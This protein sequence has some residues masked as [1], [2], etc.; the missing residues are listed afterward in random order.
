M[1]WFII[2]KC[3]IHVARVHGGNARNTSS[4]SNSGARSS[5]VSMIG[6]EESVVREYIRT[7]EEGDKRPDQLEMRSRRPRKGDSTTAVA[8][9]AALSQAALSGSHQKGSQFFR[10]YLPSREAI[11]SLLTSHDADG[12]YRPA[13]MTAIKEVVATIGDCLKGGLNH[14]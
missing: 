4:G 13:V 12:V 2:G 10:G 3:A 11:A 9:L 14:G 5:L 6:R 8:A 1:I 7:Q